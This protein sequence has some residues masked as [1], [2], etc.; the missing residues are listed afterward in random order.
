[1]GTD[2]DVGRLLVVDDD[3]LI[4]QCMKLAP[5]APEYEVVTAGTVRDAISLFRSFQPD[6]VLLDHQLPDQPGLAA[7]Q[8]FRQIDPRVP[9][10]LMTGHGSADTVINAM[11]GGAFEYVSKPFEPDDIL[12]VIDAAIATSHMARK[13][14]VLPD[15]LLSGEVAEGSDQILGKCPAMVDVFRSIGRVATRDV[16][17]LILGE[18]GTGKEVIARAIYQHS[19]RSHQVF[20]AVN[21]AAIPETL[22]ESELFGHEKGAFTG[23][24][25]RRL[26]KFEVC[27]GGT[28][29]LDE[30]GDMS[31]VM[32]SKLLRVLQQKEFE[33]VGGNAVLTSD[34]RI[35]AAT[36]RDLAAA[37][38]DKTFRTDLYYRLNEFTIQLPPLRERGEDL[39]LMIDHFFRK[40]ARSLDKE[41]SLVVPDAMQ[42]LLRYPWPGNVRE[43]QGVIKQAIL[44]S[45]SSLITPAQLPGSITGNQESGR[46]CSDTDAWEDR[47][48]AMVR[49]MIE[50]DEPAIAQAIQDRVDRITLSEVLRAVNGNLSEASSRLGISRP[51]LR[52]RLRNLGLRDSDG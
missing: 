36:N 35:I 18:T 28:L 9:V 21:C 48:R 32:Q 14:A 45:N 6:A 7:L 31:P 47:L 13:P 16:T 19:H 46:S 51:T 43:L 26:G 42:M 50:H 11:S 2:D 10:I 24:D 34:V 38:A 20:H 39:A 40:Y 1:M 49:D 3:P 8:R 27:S 4:L 25:Q 12:P 15:E 29:F 33:R 41:F 23:A 44:K 30:I 22:L 37:M 17:V 5:P 52:S